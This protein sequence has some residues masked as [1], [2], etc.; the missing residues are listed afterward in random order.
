M[1]PPPM[2]SAFVFAAVCLIGAA[3][4]TP[5]PAQPAQA[6]GERCVVLGRTGGAIVLANRC[7]VCR[8]VGIERRDGGGKWSR[9]GYM[10]APASMV[11]VATNGASGLRLADE[12][13]CGRP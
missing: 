3:I 2:P 12:R 10:V 8:A 7:G 9:S 5:A 13:A 4:A 1:H 11:T 6:Q